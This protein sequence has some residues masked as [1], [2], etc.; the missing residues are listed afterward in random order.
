MVGVQGHYH[1][2]PGREGESD[3]RVPRGPQVALVAVQLVHGRPGHATEP[4]V[5][6]ADGQPHRVPHCHAVLRGHYPVCGPAAGR[7]GAPAAAR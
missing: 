5:L 2:L 4:A 7:A 6:R 3:C 1:D